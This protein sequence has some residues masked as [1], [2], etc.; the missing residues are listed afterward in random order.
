LVLGGPRRAVEHLDLTLALRQIIEAAVELGGSAYGAIGVLSS[1]GALVHFIHTGM[2]GVPPDGAPGRAPTVAG[3]SARSTT[4]A[5]VRSSS[6]ARSSCRDVP[7][8]ARG[9]CGASRWPTWAEASRR[10]ASTH[11][12]D[13]TRRGGR[14]RQGTSY[15]VRLREFAE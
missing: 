14:R 3:C 4:C 2:D 8:T 13:V 15:G 5:S 12:G 11:G 9:T 10:R 6:A 1:H 7:A